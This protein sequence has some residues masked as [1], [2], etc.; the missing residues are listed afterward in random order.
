M[1][2]V[3]SILSPLIAWAIGYFGGAESWAANSWTW[4]ITFRRI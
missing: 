1:I 2:T 4:A 3:L